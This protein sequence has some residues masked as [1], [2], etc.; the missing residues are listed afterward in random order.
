MKRIMFLGLIALVLAQAA[1]ALETEAAFSGL[2]Q[3]YE[4]D[5]YK[6]TLGSDPKWSDR[7]E[8]PDSPEITEQVTGSTWD[9]FKTRLSIPEDVKLVSY[10]GTVVG[11]EV[12]A[13]E[14]FRLR[15]GVNK[16]EFWQDGGDVD[17][18]PI[19]WVED[20]P[21]LV[22]SLVKAKADKVASGGGGYP[23]YRL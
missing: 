21:E 7:P 15:K 12:C 1:H 10:D 8:L 14:R 19:H 16:G 22:Y 4:M 17:S 6:K 2:N 23:I 18:P 13:G 11:D 5:A 9:E 20:V 3:E